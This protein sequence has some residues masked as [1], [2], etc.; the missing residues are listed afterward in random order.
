M[1]KFAIDADEKQLHF[2]CSGDPTD[3]VVDAMTCLRKTYD[4]VKAVSEERAEDMRMFFVSQLIDKN[5][6][7]FEDVDWN[8]EGWE[9]PGC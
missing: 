5:S 8:T 4:A 7:F 9:D 6:A 3:L 1:L 2:E